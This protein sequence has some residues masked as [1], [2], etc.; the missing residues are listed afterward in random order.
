MS[1]SDPPPGNCHAMPGRSVDRRRATALGRVNA[2]RRFEVFQVGG[3]GSAHVGRQP[4]WITSRIPHGICATEPPTYL[5]IQGEKA[6]TGQSAMRFGCRWLGP[7]GRGLPKHAL[8]FHMVFRRLRRPVMPRAL[9]HDE[10]LAQTAAA[11]HVRVVPVGGDAP[12]VAAMQELRPRAA[13]CRTGRRAPARRLRRALRPLQSLIDASGQRARAAVHRQ[14][15][16]RPTVRAGPYAGTPAE[17]DAH[18]APSRRVDRSL[19]AR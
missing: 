5:C 6:F 8:L 15:A 14:P 17:A 18:A 12:V 1:G 16:R 19:Q 10:R 9:R 4:R 3:R 11:G 13:A 2:G 7:R